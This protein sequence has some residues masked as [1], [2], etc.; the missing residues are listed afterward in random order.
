MSYGVRTD[1]VHSVYDSVR[2]TYDSVYGVRTNH[3]EAP[4]FYTEPPYTE[5]VR[6]PYGIFWTPWDTF[7]LRIRR[8]RTERTESPYTYQKKPY[9]VRTYSVYGDFVQN[10]RSLRIRGT[11]GRKKFVQSKCFC[12]CNLCCLAMWFCHRKNLRRNCS[13]LN[14]HQPG[15]QKLKETFSFYL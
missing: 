6:T 4:Y 2:T 15:I 9:G 1:S 8:L 5:S 7:L 11:Y 14:V 3:T 12:K 10:V 13:S